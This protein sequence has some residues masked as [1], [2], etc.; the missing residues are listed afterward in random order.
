MMTSFEA[1]AVLLGIVILGLIAIPRIIYLFYLSWFNPE[2]LR[3]IEIR[4]LERLSHSRWSLPLL[5]WGPV[6]KRIQDVS[7]TWWL[8]SMRFISAAC[9]GLLVL[10][11]I[12][13]ITSIF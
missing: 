8:N 13:A 5:R 11:L 4:R 12:V 3:E 1:Y 6:D 10:V 2:K 9:I 7:T